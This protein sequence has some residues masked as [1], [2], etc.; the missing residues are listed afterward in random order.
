MEHVCYVSTLFVSCQFFTM[1]VLVWDVVLRRSGKLTALHHSGNTHLESQTPFVTCL[2][3]SNKI[4]KHVINLD[5]R[6]SV[7]VNENVM[8]LIHEQLTSTNIMQKGT[9]AACVLCG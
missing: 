8:K 5:Y 4:L 3:Y 7:D 9:F 2:A 6:I 1:L